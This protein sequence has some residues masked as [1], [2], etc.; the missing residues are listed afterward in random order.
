MSALSADVIA[1]K[2]RQ[3]DAAEL[4]V[5]ASTA[6]YAGGFAMKDA[7]GKL[8]PNST[9]VGVFAGLT[10]GGMPAT[11]PT[12]QSRRLPIPR[13]NVIFAAISSVDA[14]YIGKPVFCA[15]DNPADMSVTY[16][17]GARCVGRILDLEYDS[18][19]AVTGKCWILTAEDMPGL[20]A[21]VR[22][23][24]A[25][26]NFRTISGKTVRSSPYK[27]PVGRKAIVLGVEVTPQG[28]IPNY[29]TS[30][31][32]DCSKVVGTTRTSL[33]SGTVDVNNTGIVA[34]TPFALTGA[35]TPFVT[36]G[37]GDRLE[38]SVVTVGAATTDADIQVA[39]QIIEYGYAN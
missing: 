10:N 36:L 39:A 28:V 37:Q 15:T 11:T 24:T 13:L 14:T 9:A 38:V 12:G 26:S 32:L 25:C 18:N 22:A 35:A 19:G 7:N 16:T 8:V 1:N 3:G 31:A 2:G 6:V 27:C 4:E 34:D 20:H 30:A 29:A 17:A 21:N 5:K 23:I 33:L